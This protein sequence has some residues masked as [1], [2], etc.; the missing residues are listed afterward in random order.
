MDVFERRRTKLREILQAMS[1]AELS[2]HSGVSA[3]YI[4]RALKDPGDDGYK[5]IGEVTA[6]KLE[7]G[8]RKKEGWM[9]GYDNSN[10]AT[11]MEDVFA[12]WRL[13]AS[14][15]SLEV[16]DGLSV[17]AQKNALREEDWLVIRTLMRR[18]GKP[19]P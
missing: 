18:F 11:A 16:I 4:S 10:N 15:V 7:K 6:R 5:S 12:D 17:L 8:A 14:P 9:D 3:S 19:Q 2:R 1:Q 13:Q